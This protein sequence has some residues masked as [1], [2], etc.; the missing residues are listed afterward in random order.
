MLSYPQAEPKGMRALPA[1]WHDIHWLQLF[2]G[3]IW[4]NAVVTNCT[5]KHC[6]RFQPQTKQQERITT[7]RLGNDENAKN[8]ISNLLSII[9]NF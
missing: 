8:D 5:D 3:L 7:I 1:A 4:N 2:I 9:G 6:D